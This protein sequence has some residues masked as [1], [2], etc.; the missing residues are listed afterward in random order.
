MNVEEESG[1]AVKTQHS[2]NEDHDIW[3]HHFIANR[4]GNSGNSK[5]LYFGGSKI[6][7]DGDC[8]QEIKRRILHGRKAVTNLDSLLKSRDITLPTKVH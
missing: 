6:T 5:R 4:W 1:K 8:N 7:A 3:S 2:K